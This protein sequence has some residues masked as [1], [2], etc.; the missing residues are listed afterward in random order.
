[1]EDGWDYNIDISFNMSQ[2]DN[3]DAN[4][5]NGKGM[6]DDLLEEAKK[7]HL[8]IVE[9]KISWKKKQRMRKS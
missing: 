1:M 2:L 6:E 9:G 4:N 3:T 7:G 8:L 5:N